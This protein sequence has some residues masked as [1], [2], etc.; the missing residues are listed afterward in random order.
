MEMGLMFT[1]GFMLGWL[2]CG[3][4]DRIVRGGPDE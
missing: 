4:F 3:I 2:L 1:A